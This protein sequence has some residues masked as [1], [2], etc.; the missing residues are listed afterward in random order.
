MSQ[1]SREA[2]SGELSFLWMLAK[3]WGQSFLRAC[4]ELLRGSRNSVPV[5]ERELCVM[6]LDG[7][8]DRMPLGAK[9]KLLD[10][11]FAF[12]RQLAQL[13]TLCSNL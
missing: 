5:Q 9:V 4:P 13:A 12:D 1:A 10:P 8:A 3:S 6:G 7:G 11:V 2:A